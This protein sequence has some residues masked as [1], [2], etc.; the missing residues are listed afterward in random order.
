MKKNE[1]LGKNIVAGTV[2]GILAYDVVAPHGHTWSEGVDHFIEKHP[3]LTRTAIGY[4]AL[5]L[6]NLLPPSLDLFHVATKLK[7]R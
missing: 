3:V 1:N 6:A 4:I 2:A 7:K 5:H